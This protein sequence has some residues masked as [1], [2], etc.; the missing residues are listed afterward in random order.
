MIASNEAPVLEKGVLI[1]LLITDY[2]Y[3]EFFL[4]ICLV[5]VL[6]GENSTVLIPLAVLKN[7]CK[8]LT[9]HRSSPEWPAQ[10]RQRHV[11]NIFYD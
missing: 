8:K 5:V 6:M 4:V 9:S 1:T 7:E 11:I 2:H 10:N 3:E